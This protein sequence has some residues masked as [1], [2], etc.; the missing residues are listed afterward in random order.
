MYFNYNHL[1]YFYRVAALG[2][3]SSA[4][5]ELSISQPS[6]SAQIKTF[7]FY[8]NKKLFEKSGR[9]IRLTKEGDKVYSYCTRMFEISNELESVLTTN[10]KQLYIEKFKIGIS[11]QVERPFMA[12]VLSPLLKNRKK[13]DYHFLVLSEADNQMLNDLRSK[14][15]DLFITNRPVLN[16]DVLQL[17]KIEMPVRLYIS[18]NL[19]Q[20]RRS[21]SHKKDLTKIFNSTGLILP[22]EDQKLRSEID[23]FLYSKKIQ[24]HINLESDAVSVIA[25]AILDGAGTGFLPAPY[26]KAETKLGHVV[27]LGPKEGYWKHQIIAYTRRELERNPYIEEFKQTLAKYSL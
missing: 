20:S 12:D 25:R 1:Y 26:M 27:A 4:A 22:T 9:K 17:I 19:I 18:E 24:S 23:S 13:R 15:I 16:D 8:I 6:L 10:N 11:E 7:E 14:T 2:G 3:I 5:K 21:L